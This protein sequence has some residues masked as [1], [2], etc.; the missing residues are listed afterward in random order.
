MNYC[1]SDDWR[2]RR[3]TQSSSRPIYIVYS[4]RHCRS[5]PP[6]SGKY[7]AVTNGRGGGRSCGSKVVFRAEKR[8]KWPRLLQFQFFNLFS[9]YFFCCLFSFLFMFFY[10]PSRIARHRSWLTNER[11]SELSRTRPRI[12][13]D[14]DELVTKGEK[15]W[16]K[17]NFFGR[18]VASRARS[19]LFYLVSKEF[20]VHRRGKKAVIRSAAYTFPILY[21]YPSG[22]ECLQSSSWCTADACVYISSSFLYAFHAVELGRSI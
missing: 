19:L 9:L 11:V 20:A 4:R 1:S 15:P 21:I 18:R 6:A 8:Q 17:K 22:T 5:F 7:F 12:V 10:F 16:R 13:R 3:G 2:Q 14:D